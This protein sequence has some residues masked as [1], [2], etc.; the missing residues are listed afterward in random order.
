MLIVTSSFGVLE[1][2]EIRGG[3]INWEC[4]LRSILG[5]IEFDSNDF[6][7]AVSCDVFLS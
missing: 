1:I 4:F 5:I 3:W 2:E 6:Y 7:S